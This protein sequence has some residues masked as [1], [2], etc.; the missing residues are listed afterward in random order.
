M[1]HGLLN[2]GSLQILL[3]EDNPT[4]AELTVRALR[5]GGV[6]GEIIWVQDG[7]EA[8]QFMQRTGKHAQRAAGNPSLV[9]LDLKMPKVNGLEVLARLK[10]DPAT[11]AVPVV[12][13]TSSDHENDMTRSYEL[14]ANS[15]IVKPVDFGKFTEQVSRLGQYW[16]DINRSPNSI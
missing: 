8:L 1:A 2:D 15:Y 16:L 7:E 12:I 3:A 4:D 13:M 14:S 9:L 6:A 10:A 5:K 11:R